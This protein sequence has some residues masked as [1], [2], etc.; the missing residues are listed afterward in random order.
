MIETRTLFLRKMTKLGFLHCTNAPTEDAM[1]ALPD[2]DA[3]TNERCLKTVVLFHDESTFMANEDQPTQWGMKGEKMMK[4]KSKGAGIM[5]S[6]F[7]DEHNGF[8]ALSDDE[9]EAAKASKP[10]IRKYAREFLEYGESREG[11][12]T[13]DR[14]IALASRLGVRSQ[15]LPCCHG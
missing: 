2:V 10:H 7:I 4:P 14:F 13:R 1:R 9:H 15:Q 6:D 12:W 5:V 3:P 11:Y 8:L